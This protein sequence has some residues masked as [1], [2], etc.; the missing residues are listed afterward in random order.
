MSETV[1]T[2]CV[3]FCSGLIGAERSADTSRMSR[4]DLEQERQRPARDDVGLSTTCK[5][6]A[7]GR[8]AMRLGTGP[9]TQRVIGVRA[10]IG[11]ASSNMLRQWDWLIRFF[12]AGR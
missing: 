4:V 2:T 8:C 1:P 12:P 7:C 5:I 10:W 9:V 3:G 11:M 6:A